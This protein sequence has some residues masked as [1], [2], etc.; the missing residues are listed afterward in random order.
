MC[1]KQ[2]ESELTA[3][4][5]FVNVETSVKN[6]LGFIKSRVKLAWEASER[7]NYLTFTELQPTKERSFGRVE[8]IP[9]WFKKVNTSISE[10]EPMNEMELELERQKLIEYFKQEKGN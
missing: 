2:A 4:I 6:P 10:E 3:I 5:K 9:E 1:V 8:V 7:G